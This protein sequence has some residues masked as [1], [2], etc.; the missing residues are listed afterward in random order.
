MA[1][2]EDSVVVA[3]DFEGDFTTVLPPPLTPPPGDREILPSCCLAAE[4]ALSG[5]CEMMNL[6][7]FWTWADV[8]L[9]ASGSALKL[10]RPR[11]LLTAAEVSS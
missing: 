8:F 7:T 4:A 9:R 5:F 10:C 3:G 2:E 6:R 11:A 1:V